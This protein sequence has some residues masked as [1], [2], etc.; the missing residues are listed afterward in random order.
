MSSDT[1][2]W[3]TTREVARQM[4]WTVIWVQRL[5]AAKKIAATREG[6]QWRVTYSELQRLLAERAEKTAQPAEVEA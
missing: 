4:G 6:R 2:T 5:C 3:V 1:E